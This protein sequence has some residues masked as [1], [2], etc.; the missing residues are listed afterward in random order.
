M[1]FLTADLVK[2]KAAHSDNEEEP[3]IICDCNADCKEP[4]HLVL[5]EEEEYV[6]HI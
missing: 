5:Y 1:S 6:H 3:G 4:D 2:L